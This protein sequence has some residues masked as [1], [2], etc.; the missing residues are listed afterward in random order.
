LL[1]GP[2]GADSAPGP[3]PRLVDVYAGSQ[4]ALVDLDRRRVIPLKAGDAVLGTRGPHALVRR[5]SKLLGFHAD[6]GALSPLANDLG[7]IVDQLANDEVVYAAPYVVN[8][9]TLQVLGRQE[10]AVLALARDGRTLTATTEPATVPELF[11]G[12]LRWLAPDASK[13]ASR[14]DCSCQK[15]SRR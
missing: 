14:A 5:G 3:T 15:G 1:I 8:L 7:R 12:P 6:T 11:G 10:R 2:T 9:R 13:D 4:T